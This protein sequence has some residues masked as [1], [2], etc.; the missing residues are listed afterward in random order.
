MKSLRLSIAVLAV[1]AIAAGCGESDSSDSKP[2]AKDDASKSKATAEK[3]NGPLID[4][5]QEA[6][7][8]DGTKVVKIQCTTKKGAPCVQ[9]DYPSKTNYYRIDKEHKKNQD[10]HQFLVQPLF[11]KLSTVAKDMKEAASRTGKRFSGTTYIRLHADIPFRILQETIYSVGMAEFSA[12]HLK[13]PDTLPSKGAE[14]F[15]LKLRKPADLIGKGPDGLEPLALII[16]VQESYVKIS[17]RQVHM[18]KVGLTRGPRVIPKREFMTEGADGKKTLRVV[19]DLPAFY[20]TLVEIQNSAKKLGFKTPP[21]HLGI[22]ARPGT[23]WDVI[24]RFIEAARVRREGDSFGNGPD[25]LNA[26]YAAKAVEDSPLFDT[27]FFLTVANGVSAGNAKK[28]NHQGLKDFSKVMA[29][30]HRVAGVRTKNLPESQNSEDN[31]SA[32]TSPASSAPDAGPGVKKGNSPG[33]APQNPMHK[34]GMLPPKPAPVQ[35]PERPLPRPKVIAGKVRVSGGLDRALVQKYSRRQ[36]GGIKLC[37][38]NALKRDSQVKGRLNLGFSIRANG[39]VT[40][41]SVTGME[42]DAALTTCLKNRMKL[43]RFPRPKSGELVKVKYPIVLKS[44]SLGR[45]APRKRVSPRKKKLRFKPR[46]F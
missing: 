27:L 3:L 25:A 40:E 14:W 29:G 31:D 32:D 15:N 43:W 1:T 36:L 44:S 9:D 8:V 39:T 7:S 11:D 33:P 10:D 28:P 34:D 24:A 30:T 45:A 2:P 38:Q 46:V 16:F 13:R 5:T 6:I 19:H 26:F 12:L 17:V 41:I 35:Q 23:R 22:S 18:E 37:Y 20:E 21:T 42:R 4:V